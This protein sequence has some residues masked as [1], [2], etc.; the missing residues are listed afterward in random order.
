VLGADPAYGSSDWADRFVIS[1]WRCYADRMDQVAEFCTPDCLPYA[2]AWILC[3]MAGIYAPCAW[4]LEVNGP[5]VAVLTEIDSLRRQRFAGSDKDKQTMKNF[6]AGMTEF[7]YARADSL[8][9]APSA[10]GTISTLKE[11]I[12]YFETF[13]GYFARGMLGIK[14]RA[15]LEEMKWV[16]QEPGCA[17]AGSSRHKDDRVVAACLAVWFWHTKIR[18]R[19]MALNITSARTEEDPQRR[20]S[21]VEAIVA[22]QRKLLGM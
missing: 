14:S 20:M 8:T 2:F 4:N 21:P 16:T 5:G 22:R 19:L 13:K 12:N 7:L 6:L 15:L 1:L 18:A 11:K 3:Y 17:P 10:R 9:R